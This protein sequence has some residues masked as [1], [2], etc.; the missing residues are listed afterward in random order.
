MLHYW[1]QEIGSSDP[2]TKQQIIGGTDQENYEV[3]NQDASRFFT[4][5][6]E[7]PTE[8]TGALHGSRDDVYEER[9]DPNPVLDGMVARD[10]ATVLATAI[11]K[12][13]LAANKKGSNEDFG[14][15]AHIHTE[16]TMEHKLIAYFVSQLRG[17]KA[18]DMNPDSIP[19][20]AT[21]RISDVLVI[22]SKRRIGGSKML[23][24]IVRRSGSCTLLGVR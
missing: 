6:G 20:L 4:L 19:E 18:S 11:E 24:V 15:N 2:K 16:R 8:R 10:N 23:V 5:D 14:H 9:Q 21:H 12:S 13:V 3:N 1:K 7:T 17:D 22:E